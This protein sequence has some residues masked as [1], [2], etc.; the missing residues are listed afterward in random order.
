[1]TNVIY[2]V[3]T[4]N[5]I[6]FAVEFLRENHLSVIDHPSPEVTHL[7]MDVPISASAQIDALLPSLPDQ[8]TII[9][10]NIPS[11]FRYSYS[12][13]DLLQDDQYLWQNAA[14][15]AECAMRLIFQSVT[16]ILSD[17]RILLLGWGRISKSLCILLNAFHAKLS[18][19][20]R[21]NDHLAEIQA[22]QLIPVST[23]QFSDIIGQQQLIINTAPNISLPSDVLRTFK[24][25]II[26]LASKSEIHFQDLIVAKRLPERFTPESSGKLISQSILRLLKEESV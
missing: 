9:G 10:G 26:D 21:S 3:G 14:I 24:G 13:I 16:K 22:L 4:S 25:Q 6:Q 5:S 23:A 19:Y 12:T 17:C 20:S 7:L 2:P 15:T 1:M 11:E 18:I 8:I